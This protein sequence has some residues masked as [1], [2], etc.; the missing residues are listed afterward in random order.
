[1]VH[2]QV[3]G[4]ARAALAATLAAVA[5]VA[6]IPP[7]AGAANRRI[8]IGHYTWSDRAINLNLGEHVT[9]YWVGPDTQHS[10]T[11]TSPVPGAVDTDPNSNI[12]H[13]TVGDKF[14]VTFNTP[15]TFTFHCKLHPSVGGTVTVSAVPGDPT[16]EPDPIPQSNVDVRPPHLSEV[17]LRHPSMGRRGTTLRYG[18]DEAVA[19]LDAEIY[20]VAGSK[21]GHRHLAFAGWQIWKHGTVGYN[22]VHFGGRSKHFKPKSGSY[23]AF[24]RASDA[25]HNASK[26][27]KL[28]FSI[29]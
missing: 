5:V 12:P 6:A 4:R 27:I 8:A 3:S 25:S 29:R 18:T 26:R 19:K 15:G 2:R 21:D 22:R 1:V 20:R 7:A 10:V 28:P 24:L 9:W 13:H 14:Q 23:M 11:E 16:S 17:A